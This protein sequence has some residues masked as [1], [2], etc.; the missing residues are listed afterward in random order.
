[1]GTFPVVSQGDSIL[2][3]QACEVACPQSAVL[4]TRTAATEPTRRGW[5]CPVPEHGVCYAHKQLDRV[6]CLLVRET[7]SSYLDHVNQTLTPAGRP[8]ALRSA[9]CL[10]VNPCS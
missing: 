9:A 5:S 3:A 6:S 10:P 8:G 2:D 4:P 1:M 7:G